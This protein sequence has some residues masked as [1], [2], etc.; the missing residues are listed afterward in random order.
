MFKF[1]QELKNVYIFEPDGE[2]YK[3]YPND[4]ELCYEGDKLQILYVMT[5]KLPTLKNTMAFLMDKE[6]PFFY[7]PFFRSFR[8]YK[9]GSDEKARKEAI[10]Q[11]FTGISPYIMAYNAGVKKCRLE[12]DN[13]K[14]NQY[15]SCVH[16]DEKTIHNK[17]YVNLIQE[18]SEK[19]AEE[20]D[21]N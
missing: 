20:S 5:K 16:F 21:S 19:P 18:F 11:Y 2:K 8:T 6:V 14:I 12:V 1:P 13:L 7:D 4:R 15:I 17:K 10:S 3:V 9:K